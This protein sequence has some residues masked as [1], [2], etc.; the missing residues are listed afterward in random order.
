MPP[1]LSALRRARPLSALFGLTLFVDLLIHALCGLPPIPRLLV[2][3]PGGVDNVLDEL[4]RL[5][6]IL[7]AL[8]LPLSLIPV[9]R[10]PRLPALWSTGATLVLQSRRNETRQYLCRG[11]GVYPTREREQGAEDDTPL[12]E[13]KREHHAA[14]KA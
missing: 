5:L 14:V 11:T 10:T 3:I 6:R 4:L 8:R 1:R 9:M 13:P 2:Y 7:I 12:H